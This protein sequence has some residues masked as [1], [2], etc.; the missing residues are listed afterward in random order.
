MPM[1][2]TF[3]QTD[4]VRYVYGELNKAENSEF[5]NAMMLDASLK[6][7]VRELTQLQ[8]DLDRVELKPSQKVIDNI[9]SYAKSFNLHS[10]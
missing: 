1:I 3:T 9:L 8:S 2:K 5:E 7:E 4:A 10:K 6:N